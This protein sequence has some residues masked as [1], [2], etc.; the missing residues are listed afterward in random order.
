MRPWSRPRA[1]VARSRRQGRACDPAMGAPYDCE[2]AADGLTLKGHG[3][4]G[5]LKVIVGVLHTP[6]RGDEDGRRA[7]GGRRHLRTPTRGDETAE[8]LQGLALP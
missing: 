8:T 7:S 3:R 6:T 5:P 4:D 2:G 1:A